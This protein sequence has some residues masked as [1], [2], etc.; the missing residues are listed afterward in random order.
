MNADGLI[1][2]ILVE[3]TGDREA[4]RRLMTEWHMAL[5]G[6]WCTRREFYA[7]IAQANPETAALWSL[8]EPELDESLADLKMNGVPYK[9]SEPA[10]ESPAGA[11]MQ[12]HPTAIDPLLGLFPDPLT[13]DEL[14]A[15][16]RALWGDPDADD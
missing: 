2:R 7:E 14:E 16:Y 3:T 12:Q 9:S 11:Y 15:A 6:D 5:V 4:A 8:M 1:D 13:T 10:E